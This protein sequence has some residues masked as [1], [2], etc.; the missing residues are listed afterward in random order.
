MTKHHTD[1]H[2]DPL[3]EFLNKV[4]SN[5]LPYI[6][7]VVLIIA[8]VAVG[9]LANVA[10]ID[11]EKKQASEYST[12]LDIEDASERAAAL[13]VIADSNSKYAA[14]ALYLQASAAMDAEDY[15]TAKMA[16]SKL[17]ETYPTFEFTPDA[18]EGLGAIAQAQGD[19]AAAIAYYEE[20]MSTWPNSF[21]AVRQPY[22]IGVCHEKNKALPEAIAA[23]KEQ[24]EV[25]VDSSVSFQAQQKLNQLY[26]SNPELAPVEE[27]VAP[28]V[29]APIEGVVEN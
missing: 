1:E 11:K 4:Q 8:L 13:A 15:E 12:A 18:V 27:V 19:Y 21:A 10:K 28:E 22:N 25:F 5:P 17:R 14:E 2:V 6:G 26:A 29:V 23:Y 3:H 7:G 20:V 24:L 9:F 16:Y